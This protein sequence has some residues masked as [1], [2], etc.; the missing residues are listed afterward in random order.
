MGLEDQVGHAASR[1]SSGGGIGSGWKSRGHS[2]LQLQERRTK[3]RHRRNLRENRALAWTQVRNH[4]SWH[5]GHAYYCNANIRRNADKL[6]F[7]GCP[8]GSPSMRH[9]RGGRCC[10][11]RPC[12][13][14]RLRATTSSDRATCP[15]LVP[16]TRSMV[17]RLPLL[18]EAQ[19]RGR[20][21][22]LRGLTPLDELLARDTVRCPGYRLQ[23][24]EPD[25]FAA[26]YAGAI[27]AF[28]YS[29][30]RGIHVRK[31]ARQ[32]LDCQ[33]RFVP[34]VHALNLINRVAPVFANC[35][36]AGV[37][38][39]LPHQFVPFCFQ[40]RLE[41]HHLSLC[42][43]AAPLLPWSGPYRT[44]HSGFQSGR[45]SNLFLTASSPSRSRW[46]S[47]SCVIRR[48][49]SPSE[50]AATWMTSHAASKAWANCSAQ[51]KVAA[52]ESDSP[53]GQRILRKSGAGPLSS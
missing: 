6:A 25:R 4:R 30:K 40:C 8:S 2:R 39:D 53:T 29:P 35:Q 49:S 26:F 28:R 37:S 38:V 45:P 51:S 19:R 36:L 46:V 31:D 42:H 11:D 3:E 15:P 43:L 32:P 21:G 16:L 10:G 24:Y 52:V 34:L 41:T 22:R 47:Q 44:R 23:P 18:V 48:C 5:P 1:S 33:H 17:T 7:R 9:G 13:W 27:R 14:E 12:S 20:A 50:L